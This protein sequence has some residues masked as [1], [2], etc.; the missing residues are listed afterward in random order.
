M[1][2]YLNSVFPAILLFLLVVPCLSALE[3]PKRADGYV[4]DQA[5]ILSPAARA[6][7]EEILRAYEEKTSNQVVVATFP[8]LEG[9]SLEDFSLRLAETWKVGQKGRDNG[10]IFLI[11]KKD[12]KMRIEVGYGLEGVLPDAL[13][14]QIIRNVIAPYFRTGDYSNGIVAGPD[15][16]IKATQGEFKGTGPADGSKENSKAHRAFIAGLLVLFLLPY[17]VPL[18]SSHQ[19]G[20]RGGRFG[21]YWTGGFGG[22]GFGG[23]G[24]SGGGGGFGGGGASGGW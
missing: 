22:G 11:F 15:A 18:L 10:V 12:R 9:N 6:N 20:R 23:G 21:G 1:R 3:V 2:K 19:I 17:L 13:A 24:F 14:G 8:S 16:I 5:G 7:L 4:T